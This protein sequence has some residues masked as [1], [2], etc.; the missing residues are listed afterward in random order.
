MI[1]AL[2]R[3][4]PALGGL[5]GFAAGLAAGFA[6]GG[7]LALEVAG[8]QDAAAE[9]DRLRWRLAGERLTGAANAAAHAR[10]LADRDR[11][12]AASED[13]MAAERAR[14]RELETLIEELRHAPPEHD[15]PLS[16][17]AQRYFD[18]LRGE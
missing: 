4:L 2:A 6:L 3:L 10:E 8:W 17:T 5:K 1:A 13:A 16:P 11:A 7:W 9:R 14:L 15:K 18:G 12:L